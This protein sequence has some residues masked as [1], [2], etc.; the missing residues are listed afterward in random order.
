MAVTIDRARVRDALKGFDFGRLFIEELGWD[1]PPAGTPSVELDGTHFTMRPVAHKRGMVVYRCDAPADGIVPDHPTRQKIERQVARAVHEHII[2]YCDSKETVQVW[3]WVRR[4]PGRP[5]ASR[6]TTIY[7]DQVGETLLQKLQ[8]ISFSLQEEKALTIS[9]VANRARQ[10]FDVERVTKRFYD[11][12]RAEH[13]AFLQFINGIQAQGDREWYAS[14]MLNRL[15]FVYFIQKK[16]FLDGD[17]DYL[18]KRMRTIQSRTGKDRFLSFYRHFL[19]RLFHEGLGHDERT[20]ELDVLLGKVPYL[21]G[22]LFDLHELE[23][24]YESIAIPDDAFERL[25]DF[26]DGYDWHLD[27]R[28]LRADD[29]IKPRRT[30]LHLREVHQ[31]KADG[32]VLHERR[33]HRVHQQEHGGAL[34]IRASPR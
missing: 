12:F 31:P 13:G 22:G 16:G 1:R 24:R 21:N 5:T 9:T 15:M 33:H 26:F 27:E 11:Q 30:R 7:K 32:R 34:R 10:A 4:E 14:L 28:P 2:I 8:N 6:Q 23:H 3:Q 29:E 19:L 20:A 17:T 25:F 18:R